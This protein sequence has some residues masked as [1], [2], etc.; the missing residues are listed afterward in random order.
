MELEG[1]SNAAASAAFLRQLR[2]QRPEPLIVI[3][4]N[5]PARD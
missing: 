1:N 5:S 2:G 4:D 3:G